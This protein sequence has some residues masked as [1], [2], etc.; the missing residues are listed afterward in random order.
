LYVGQRNPRLERPIKELKGY[1]KVLLQP[2]ERQRVTI[3]LNGRS[4]AYYNPATSN[5]VIDGDTF[6]IGVGAASNDI[7]L[8]GRLLSPYRQSL[9]VANSNPLPPTVVA[10][11]KVTARQLALNS[12]DDQASSDRMETPA[13]APVSVAP[14]ASSGQ[15]GSAQ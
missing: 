4:L 14:P 12:N 2:G 11:T 8:N 10:A 3:E 13:P 7:R 6:D 1:Q 15:G 5:W 9:S